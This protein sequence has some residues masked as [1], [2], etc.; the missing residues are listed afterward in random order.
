MSSHP[1]VVVGTT[2]DYIDLIR[3]GH[4]G[5]AIFVTD[6]AE[7]TKARESKPELHEELLW[8]LRDADQVIAALKSHLYRWDMQPG[9]VACFDCE[10]LE[11]TARIAM[12]LDLPFPSPSAVVACRNKLLS[13]QMWSNNGLPCP[14]AEKIHSPSELPDRLKRLNLPVILKPLTGSGSE[15]V[16][17]CTTAEDC[18]R[19][20]TTIQARLEQ[21]PDVRMY[22]PGKDGS[23]KMDSRREF[24]METF[25]DGQEYSC[26]VMLEGENLEIIRI[27]KKLPAPDQTLGTT[28]AYMIPARLPPGLDQ[29][30]FER[31]LHKAARTLGLERAVCMVDF[32]VNANTA[33]LLEL[34]PRPGGDCLRWLIRESC[35][36]D[37]LGLAL[38]FAAGDPI[39]LPAA[40]DWK[41]LIGVRFFARKAGIIRSIDDR[42]LKQDHRITSYY[43]KARPGDRVKLPPED[44][45]SRI[46][47]HAIFKAIPP[48][49]ILQ[50]CLEIEAKLNIDME[51]AS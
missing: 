30:L 40:S 26:D 34:T 1:I 50:Q 49:P 45:D 36:L 27:A 4:P 41:S 42:H 10:S 43:L 6:P 15:L 31:Q 3:N 32:I 44:Y 20:L 29:N 39:R 8:D 21:H 37:M 22:K 28:L 35:G 19:A 7:R 46:L 17:K 14:Q 5:R 13:K 11:L 18:R 47:G 51:T 16:F 38:D 33:Y 25:I 48:D 23:S 9:G 2:A 12:A 24:V